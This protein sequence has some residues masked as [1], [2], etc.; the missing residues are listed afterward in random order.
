[1]A[2]CPCKPQALG[3]RGWAWAAFSRHL[4]R[5]RGSCREKP[6]GQGA[7]AQSRAQGGQTDRA[8]SALC[9]Q[10]C[11]PASAV[12][13]WPVGERVLVPNPCSSSE[14]TWES[15]PV[16]GPAD[17]S[18]TPDSRC[19]VPSPSLC[20]PLPPF[21]Q[22]GGLCGQ[23]SY[24]GSSDPAAGAHCVQGHSSGAAC[25]LGLSAGGRAS[26]LGPERAASLSQNLGRS[27]RAPALVTA[28]TT[29]A[30]IG[31]AKGG[32]QS[33]PR[34]TRCGLDPSAD[35]LSGLEVRLLSP[36]TWGSLRLP[37]FRT[38]CPFVTPPHPHIPDHP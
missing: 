14:R 35:S 20:L 12:G 22:N 16:T 25:V 26:C 3:S 23:A 7:G 1:M 30:G 10:R 31:R 11:I 8:Y 9:W 36:Q 5:G 33:R 13:L 19:S 4:G 37:I 34:L 2:P 6:G 15:S 32:A 28:H 24:R 38:H 21:R 17:P 29:R 27:H 18:R